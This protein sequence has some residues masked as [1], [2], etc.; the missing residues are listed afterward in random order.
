MITFP[1]AVSAQQIVINPRS[2]LILN[3]NVALVV[4]NAAFQN[5]GTFSA[6][7]STVTFSG[8]TDTLTSY[9]SGSNPTVFNN[10][11]VAKPAYGVALKSSV[12][13][14]DVLAVNAGNLYT[15]SNLIL[16]SDANLTARV[17]PVNPTSSIIGKANVQRFFPARRAWRLLTA[18]VTNSATILNSWQNKG[19]YTVGIG[20][21]VTGAGPSG[22]GGNGLDN[23]QQNTASMKSWDYGSQAYIKVS[24]S[25]IPISA[26]N[27][28]SAD[29]T[30]YFTFVRGD[31]NPGNTTVGN[32]NNTT[33]TSI[34]TLQTGNQTFTVSPA[35]GKYSLIGNPYASP[36][37]FDSLVRNNVLKRF[38]VWDP[39]INTVGAFV[40]FDDLD[41]DGKYD[42]SIAATNQTTFI[43]SSQAFFIQTINNGAASVTFK[44]SGKS[45]KYA[46]GVFRPMNTT[47]VTPKII[48]SLNLL[49]ADNTTILADGVFAQFN[50]DFSAEVDMYDALKFGNT[51]ENLSITRNSISLA[52]ERRPALLDNDTL[53]LK[54]ATTTQR[55]Y[56]FVFDAVNF[57]QPGLTGFLQDSYLGT[58]TPVNLSGTTT[59]NFSIDAVAASAVANRFRIVFKQAGVL[60]V[61]ISSIKAYET[62]KNIEVE[63][64]VEDEIN[65]DKYDVEK[66]TDGVAFT[67]VNAVNVIGINNSR[68]NYQWLDAS[69]VQGNNFYRIKIYDHSGSIKY[70]TTVKVNTGKA[71]PGFIVYPNPVTGNTINLVITNEPLG[72]YQL[73]LSNAIGQI[74]LSKSVQTNS[75]NVSQSIKIDS[76]MPAGIYQLEIKGQNKTSA[77]QQVIVE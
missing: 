51:N 43:Q 22:V 33:L 73:T 66:S 63:W 61:T 69:P 74:L 62:N 8:Y 77:I 48:T 60:P 19:V 37:S 11:S 35:A 70:S 67:K 26:G 45:S 34:G 54:L 41:G 24:N 49:N 27:T 31:R 25:K 14:I 40:M 1:V 38:Y 23:S 15:D 5:N 44:E 3:G 16:R 9:V 2:N 18:P 57:D 20:M 71:A 64:T 32:T 7:K 75:N 58:N 17:A 6:G 59:V 21:L 39:A 30:G 72:T 10:L 36:F 76:K 12:T 28:G 29:N 42:T 65:I 52:A 68:N 46:P 55:G 47:S 53:F 4:N 50:D 13:V 56:Q